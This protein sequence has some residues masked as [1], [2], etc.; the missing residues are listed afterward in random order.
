MQKLISKILPPVVADK[1]GD[2]TRIAH[3]GV[4]LI[5]FFLAGFSIFS[6]LAPIGGAVI[7]EGIVKVATNR[8]TVQHLEGGII[9]EISIKEGGMVQQ[10]QTLITLEDIKASSAYNYLTDQ[11]DALVAKQARLQAEVTMA[12]N[13]SYPESLTSRRSARIVDMLKKESDVFNSRRKLLNDTVNLLQIQIEE[14]RESEQHLAQQ[15]KEI[16]GN[17]RIHEEQVKMREN[18][19]EKNFVG[20]ADVL[21]FQ[22]ALLEKR[23]QLSEQ[24]SELARTR[25]QISSLQLA[26]VNARNR[27]VQDAEAEL[28]DTNNQLAGTEEQIRPLKDTFERMVVTAPITGQV[29]NLQVTTIG[30]VIK[31]GEPLMDIVPETADLVIEAKVNNRDIDSVHLGQDAELQLN[32]YNLR[33][34]PLVGGKVIYIASD[35]LVDKDGKNY[36]YLSHIQVS[37]E[38]LI[39]IKNIKLEAG[40]PV[41]SYIKTQNRTLVE[42]LASPLIDRMRHSF[43]DE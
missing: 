40:M 6:M 24:S 35:A 28:K 15:L 20:K 31:P 2:A 9:K 3:K 38:D 17:I 33:T 37:K 22:Q 1:T 41:T 23:G 26:K 12:G 27:Y 30:G 29:I 32:A 19:L 16:Q 36:F 34:T 5:L 39:K 4:L 18:L 11:R 43:R 7:A 10:G 14:S 42:Y 25:E 13:I 8:K 21:N